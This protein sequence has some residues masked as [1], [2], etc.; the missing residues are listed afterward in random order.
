MSY[1]LAVPAGFD[2][3]AEI[4]EDARAWLSFLLET[5]RDCD[6]ASVGE[7][8]H[9]LIASWICDAMLSEC[10]PATFP[11]IA[12]HVARLLNASEKTDRMDDV[13]PTL[14][15]LVETLLCSEGLKV[16]PFRQFFSQSTS[17]LRREPALELDLSF[18][19]KRMLLY[20]AGVLPAPQAP[21]LDSIQML[22]HRF[23]LS[24]CADTVDALTVQLECLTG[25]GAQPVDAGVIEPWLGEVISGLVVQR[26]RNY[27]LISAARL[28]RLH[29]YLAAGDVTPGRD[30]LYDALCM[31]RQI[32]GPFGW[33]GPETA[34][35]R[36]VNAAMREEMEFYLV[37]T[38]E[39]LW[40]LAERSGR[41]RLF[42]SIPHYVAPKEVL[43]NACC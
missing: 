36:K 18:A 34:A 27:D 23:R 26:L 14:R 8:C 28:L 33:Y 3:T 7:L 25:W 37:T 38:L 29:G 19:D 20:R 12:R 32:R 43:A 10:V 4:A 17:I 6:E 24:A 41:W 16:E 21:S 1:K 13:K 2:R 22:S 39:C 30:D 35:L 11:E 40:T 15:L 31:H 9:I 42:G 5:T